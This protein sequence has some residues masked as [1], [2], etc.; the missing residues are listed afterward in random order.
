MHYQF[1]DEGIE[2]LCKF[3]YVP[4]DDDHHTHARARLVLL[5]EDL[6]KWPCFLP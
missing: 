1:P 4:E 6:G 5:F 2:I 3:S